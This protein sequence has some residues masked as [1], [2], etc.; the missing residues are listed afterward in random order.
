M[1]WNT[2]NI[3]AWGSSVLYLHVIAGND[4]ALKNVKLTPMQKQGVDMAI[5]YVRLHVYVEAMMVKTPVHIQ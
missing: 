1:H 5:R 3:M 2:V 4:N